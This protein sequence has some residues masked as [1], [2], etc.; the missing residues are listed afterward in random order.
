MQLHERLNSQRQA[1]VVVQEADSFAEVKNRIHMAVIGDLGPQ[2][3]HADT[4]PAALRI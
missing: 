2:F 3:M 4:N 1:P